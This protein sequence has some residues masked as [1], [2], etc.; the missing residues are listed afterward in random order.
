MRSTLGRHPE[1]RGSLSSTVQRWC[2][3]HAAGRLPPA[4]GSRGR[5]PGLRLDGI[6]REPHD[7]VRGRDRM[8]HRRD[9]WGKEASP[10]AGRQSSLSPGHGCP[11]TGHRVLA[12]G[13]PVSRSERCYRI[14]RVK[15]HV[16]AQDLPDATGGEKDRPGRVRR[17]TR[18]QRGSDDR[19]T[20]AE[21]GRGAELDPGAQQ[22]GALGPGRP[23]GHD[24]PD[25]AGE[26]RGGGAALPD[27]PQRVAVPALSQGAGD[28]QRLPR[29]ALHADA[30]RAARGA[31]P[32]DYYGIFYH[33]VASTHI[34]ALCHTWDERRDVERPRSRSGRSPSTA[35]PS[36][37]SSTGGRAS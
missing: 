21:R 29:A 1:P 20:T 23:A 18:A 11:A 5:P 33:G 24:Q 37:R 35:P 32:L 4:T 3:G 14:D 27:R 36:A 2:R 10:S 13:V 22:L 15:F 7:S 8:P 25:H 28:Q 9:T 6:H 12:P 31:S 30:W 19:A 16:A 26:A 17:D 34:D